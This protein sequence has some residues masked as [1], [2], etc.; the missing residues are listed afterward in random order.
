MFLIHFSVEI[1]MCDF[2]KKLL[3]LKNVLCIKNTCFFSYILIASSPCFVVGL[4]AYLL[5]GFV[6]LFCFWIS[7]RSYGFSHFFFCLKVC[8]CSEI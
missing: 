5:W 7:R 4:L 8:L 1:L 6:L 3:N 2:S